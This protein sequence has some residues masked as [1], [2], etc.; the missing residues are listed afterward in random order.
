M[1]SFWIEAGI[2]IALF[3]ALPFAITASKSRLKGRVG[4]AAMMIGLAFGSMFDP[5]AARSAEIIRKKSE[6]AEA[7]AN[8]A[9]PGEE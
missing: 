2:I 7:D 6:E 4:G 9:P 1:A 3:A 5:A 8:G